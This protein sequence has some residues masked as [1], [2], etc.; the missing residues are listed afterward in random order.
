MA[1]RQVD[2]TLAVS[3]SR[4]RLRLRLVFEGD[5]LRERCR[6]RC[7]GRMNTRMSEAAIE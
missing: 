3:L 2:A 1:M 7:E 4:F 6:G 5:G